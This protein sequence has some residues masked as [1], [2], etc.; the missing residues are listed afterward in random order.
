M[1]NLVHNEKVKLTASLLNTLSASAFVLGILTPMFRLD[2]S[3]FKTLVPAWLVGIL[4]HAVA[5]VWLE[6]LIEPEPQ[7][8]S[9]PRPA[10]SG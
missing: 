2:A 1:A 4:L 6:R 10:P 9:P 8:L 3:L 5:S 7:P